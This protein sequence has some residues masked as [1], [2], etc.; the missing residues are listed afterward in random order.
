MQSPGYEAQELAPPIDV[1]SLRGQ[2]GEAGLED[3]ADE[4]IKTYAGDA[5][6]RMKALKE[7]CEERDPAAIQAAAHPYKSASATVHAHRLSELLREIEM[8]GREGDAARAIA[9]L[10][11]ALRE[12][13][14]VLAHCP[15]LP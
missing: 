11:G 13:E 8:A 5:P 4:L 9:L 10:P 2:L 12:H 3:L 14:A 1:A 6:F 7:A 15:S